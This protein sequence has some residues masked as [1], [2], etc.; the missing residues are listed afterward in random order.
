MTTPL[1]NNSKAL[2]AAILRLLRPLVRLLLRNGFSYGAFAE[3]AK[4]VYADVAA[5]EFAIEDR[6][7]TDR[8]SAVTGLSRKEVARLRRL[9]PP[10]DDNAAR[11]YHRAVR[12]ISGWLRDPR[13][14][15]ADGTPLP[16]MIDPPGKANDRLNE[17]SFAELIRAYSGDAT[18]H[19]ILD[20]LLR[21]GT[22][23]RNANGQVC[24]RTTAYIP[25]SGDAAKLHIL[26]S[27]VAL[28]IN[29]I[30]HNLHDDAPPRFQRKVAYDNLPREALPQLRQ[31]AAEYSQHLLQEFDRLLAQQD[32]DVHA[33]VRGSGRVQA[34][35]GIYYFEEDATT[36]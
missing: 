7:Q 4:W 13:F 26:G 18:A 25:P 2:S 24:L 28:L 12:I 27:D 5:K 29:T 9:E 11:Q 21:A 33:D 1:I 10:D 16:L 19:A 8:V 23:E 30:G 34:G 20:K 32:R 36:E 14:T 22:V 3:L 31:L 15:A 17:P 35:I 6:K